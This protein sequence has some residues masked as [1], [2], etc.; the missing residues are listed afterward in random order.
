MNLVRRYFGFL[1][2]LVALLGGGPTYALTPAQQSV[3]L[4]SPYSSQARQFFARLPNQPTVGDAAR[5]DTLIRTLVSAGIWSRL[6]L[7]NIYAAPDSATALTN[8][9]SASYAATAIG[10]PTFVA[11]QGFTSDGAA[12]YL[13][14]GYTPSTAGGQ[15]TLNSSSFGVYIRTNNEADVTDIGTQNGG[16]TNKAKL[17]SRVAGNAIYPA[18][19]TLSTSS[20]TNIDSRGMF[21]VARTAADASALYRN[22]A[23][24]GTNSDAS[25]ALPTQP[26]VVLA[27]NINGTIGQWT[28]RQTSA[29]FI[30]GGLDATQA[31]VLS[32]AI[33]AYM[34]SLGISVY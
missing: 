18:N 21:V 10:N 2:V 4:T 6:D 1:L 17:Q 13:T 29:A 32:A 28:T 16:G 3:L 20:V 14:T 27:L 31:A 25:A 8:L 9:I 26:F 34:T 12:S 5:Y 15:Y 11:Y 22:N 23:S 30:G 24:I 7:L 33:N 19:S